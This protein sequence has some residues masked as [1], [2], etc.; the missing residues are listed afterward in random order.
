MKDLNLKLKKDILAFCFEDS[1]DLLSIEC[2]VSSFFKS[3]EESK[4]KTLQVLQILLDENLV[5]AGWALKDG[6]FKHWNAK[7]D[8]IMKEIKKKWDK[9]DRELLLGDIVWFILTEKGKKEFEFLNRLPELKETDPF[10]F[11]D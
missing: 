3:K 7:S 4:E 10:Y 11:D 9:I 8:E 2:I 6:S 5:Q 1:A